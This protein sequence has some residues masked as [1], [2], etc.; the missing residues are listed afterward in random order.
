MRD[1]L[2]SPLTHPPAG[3]MADLP[4]DDGMRVQPALSGPILEVD[5]LTVGFGNA[6]GRPPVLNGVNFSLC[7]GEILGLVGAS[8]SGKSLLARSLL[9]LEKPARI[10]SGSIRIMGEDISRSSQKRVRAIR[11]S[12]I[13]YVPQNP[14]SALDP[15]YSI[16][17]QFKEVLKSH[18]VAHGNGRRPDRPRTLAD[19]VLDW[20]GSVDI[21]EARTRIKQFPHQWSRGMLQRALL[22]MSFSPSPKIIILDE[23]TSALDPTITLQIISLISALRDRHE[24]AVILITHDLAIANEICDSIA[25]LH[26]GHIVEQGRT[27][28]VFHHPRH[29]YTRQ[30]ISNMV[31]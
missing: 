20:M 4:H 25:V 31:I 1:K 22:A 13:T 3:C 19:K 9:R 27:K 2:V 24:T 23:V 18:R 30:L 29:D 21:S 11:G 17:F 6:N 10:L 15:V 7:P 8:G 5:G 14:L 26:R 16:R 28:D 12:R